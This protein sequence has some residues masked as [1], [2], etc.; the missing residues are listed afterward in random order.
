MEGSYPEIRMA[1]HLPGAFDADLAERYVALDR[2]ARRWDER[3]GGG[4]VFRNLP[5]R[6]PAGFGSAED[7]NA[8]NRDH[9]KVLDGAFRRVRAPFVARAQNPGPLFP[10]V[11]AEPPVAVLPGGRAFQA[12]DG[13]PYVPIGY[14]HNLDWT[15]LEK[16]NTLADDY[17]PNAADRWFAKLA[18]NGVNLVRMMVETPPSGNLEEKVGTFRYEHMLWLD[19]VVAAARKSGVRLMLTPYDTFWMNVR[20]ETSPYWEANGGPLGYKPGWYEKPELRAAH[21][22]RLHW[23]IDR[24]GNLGT[25]FA[26]E[27]MNEVDL[28]WDAPPA[29]IGKWADDV[30]EDARAYQ[31]KRWGVARLFTLS[32]ADPLPRGPLADLAF[33]RP[34]L[35]IANVHLYIGASRDPREPWVAVPTEA[36]G[37]RHALSEVRDGRPF[38]DTENGPIDRWVPDPKLDDAVFHDQS[39]SHLASGGAGSGLRWPYRGPHHLSDGMLAHLKA[40]RRFCDSVDWRALSGAWSPIEI[41]GSG[42]VGEGI[43]GTGYR[44]GEHGMA[45]AA[46]KGKLGAAMAGEIRVT[47][48]GARAGRVWDAEAGRWIGYAE[49]GGFV[50]PGSVRSAALV[51]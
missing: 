28:W 37:V 40:M 8:L 4:A 42:V 33:R 20:Q 47:V 44:A 27:P 49:G 50:L 46:R 32:I 39:W 13:K 30:V 38:M 48:P 11:A 34:D 41:T 12:A 6:Q 21:K 35:D 14:N 3:I 23:L 19:R 2:T 15:E 43:V 25:V 26:W 22:R 31:R 10:N 17:D 29:T 45:F 18:A 16:A 7:L 24:Y 1:R 51:W 5:L 36:E 9:L